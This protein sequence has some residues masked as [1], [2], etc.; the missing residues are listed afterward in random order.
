MPTALLV[1]ADLG[2][3]VPPFV[4]VARALVAR[5]W[6][7]HLLGDPTLATLAAREGLGFTTSTGPAYDPLVRRGTIGTIRDITRLFA[8]QAWGRAAV[9]AATR[10]AADVVVVD[11]LLV[12]TIEA[13]TAAG[14]PTVVLSH[15]LLRYLRRSFGAGPVAAVMRLRGARA[16]PAY[17]AAHLLLVASDAAF[18]PDTPL[19]ANAVPIGAV[20]QEQPQRRERAGRPLVL[21]S[22]SSIFY[23]G[24]ERVL[25]TVLDGLA[26][27]PVDVVVT[28]GRA[29]DPSA[30]VAPA[31]ATVRGFVDHA[32]LLPEAALVVGHGGQATTVRALAHG[33]PVLV[34]PMH[35]MLDQP[36]IGRAVAAAGVGLTLP[37]RAT[38]GA[39]RA[40]AA[41]LLADERIRA[42]AR[43]FG[44]RLAGRHAAALAADELERLVAAASPSAVTPGR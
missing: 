5:G 8:D 37:K 44:D 16:L 30:L 15:T 41:H 22:L 9:A 36:M 11:A 2:G 23:P 29:V 10:I 31:N 27:L 13:C 25:Q 20:L 4:G 18:D 24:Q 33:V 3:N 1:T 17:D 39:V 34:I 28:T 26:E 19:P 35:P 43:A 32:E 21:V 7:V 12:G 42:A 6:T 14:L 40:A 38:A